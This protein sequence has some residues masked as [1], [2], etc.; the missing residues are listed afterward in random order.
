MKM[1]QLPI[2]PMDLR[3]RETAAILL[4]SVLSE[5]SRATNHRARCERGLRGATFPISRRTTGRRSM[6]PDLICGQLKA[7]NPSPSGDQAPVVQVAPAGPT[8]CS[9]PLP[10]NREKYR[11]CWH[12]R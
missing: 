2:Y 1:V 8:N 10:S 6:F 4:W 11:E 12:R 7:P 9:V 3:A 5:G